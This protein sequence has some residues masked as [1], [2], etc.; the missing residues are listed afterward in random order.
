[1]GSSAAL[2]KRINQREGGEAQGGARKPY[3]GV[4][5]GAVIQAKYDRHVVVYAARHAW[6]F[7]RVLRWPRLSFMVSLLSA[8]YWQ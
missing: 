5:A 6:T 1:M 2:M 8:L 7:I 4:V 3:G